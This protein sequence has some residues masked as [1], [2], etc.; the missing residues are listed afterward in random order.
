VRGAYW[1]IINTLVSVPIAFGVNLLVARV[2]GVE[3]Y[4]RL[5]FLTTLLEIS[6]AVLA[7]GVGPGVIQFGAK[8]HS[9][10]HRD[11]VSRLLSSGQGFRIVVEVPI[12][13]L[14]LV[15]VLQVSPALLVAAIVLGVFIP[16]VLS[17]A[18][19]AL[20]IE[21]KTAEAAQ[22]V[23]V[24][25]L[26]IQVAV[27]VAV[28]QVGTP[29][30][31]WVTRLAGNALVVGLALVFVAR[32]YRLALFHPRIPPRFPTGFWHYALP[33]GIAG[34]L[35]ILVSS[36]T[37]VFALTIWATPQAV[38]AYALAFGLAAHLFAPAQA[39]VGPLVPAISGLREVDEHAVLPALMRTVRAAST[40]AGLLLAVALPAL[41]LLI[42]TLYGTSFTSAAPLLLV[43]GV[44]AGVVV[45]GNPI[46]A[47][48]Q[49][50]LAG[51]TV[52]WSNVAGLAVN[53]V[54]IVALIPFIGAWGAVIANGVGILTRLVVIMRSEAQALDI[55]VAQLLRR[56][57]PVLLGAASGLLAWL[58]ASAVRPT[59]WVAAA[60]AAAVG[61]A[62][63]VLLI[64]IS[65]SG[66]TPSD[67]HA[68]LR[69][70]PAPV[71]RVG[72]PALKV[73]TRAAE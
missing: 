43:T 23:L 54:A 70:L 59:P 62:A 52:L 24:S 58:A 53:V 18:P 17:G 31:I 71:A 1:T 72:T 66:M 26:V 56:A 51:R 57:L 27:V 67:G 11:E 35:A 22:V 38:G 34:L 50:R 42:P 21:N 7:L 6:T 37:E 69:A 19:H 8:A 15:L 64:V 65:R 4:G 36:R 16:A 46:Q 39:L 45:A 32:D 14:L 10:R 9:I 73:L 68:V 63:Y 60:F 41:A 49:A 5:A 28:L 44:F 55:A 40:I 20:A 29:D 61:G 47:F 25:G 3:E 2:L 33:T 12:L 30:A 48:V 13:T